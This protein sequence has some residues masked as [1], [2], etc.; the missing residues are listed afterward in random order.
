[1]KYDGFNFNPYLD[2]SDIGRPLLPPQDI[3]DKKIMGKSGTYFLDKR[4]EPITIPVEV[5]LHEDVDLTY[6]EKTR[7]IAGKL[8]KTEPKQL[9]FEL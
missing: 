7:F 4:H 5:T 6:R 8:N 2:I 3:I 9:I 1:L